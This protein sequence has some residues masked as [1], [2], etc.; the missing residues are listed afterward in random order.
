MELLE[1]LGTRE[2]TG[3]QWR[4]LARYERYVAILTRARIE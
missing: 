2:I 3:R 1:Q 4:R